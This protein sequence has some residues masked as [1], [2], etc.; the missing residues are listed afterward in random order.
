MFIYKYILTNNN[1]FLVILIF[2]LAYVKEWTY[3]EYE[4]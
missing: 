2:D 4:N 3:I 1:A